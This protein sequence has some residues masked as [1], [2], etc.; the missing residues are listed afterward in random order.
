MKRLLLA[1]ALTLAAV[2]AQ[3]TVIQCDPNA[4][5]SSTYP[6]VACSAS[7]AL[8]VS[9]GGATGTGTLTDRSGTIAA[10]GT[11]Q[12]LAAANTSRKYIFIQNTSTGNLYVNF[13]S[14]ASVTVGSILIPAN[15]SFVMEQGYI[16][17]Q[18][19]NIIGATTSQTYIAKE[20]S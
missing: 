16:S 15:S 1:A 12:Q 18:V 9:N 13:G 8:V 19:I 4:T 17:T 5:G 20:G 14:A 2:G 11:S 3:A 10:G 6:N 7:G